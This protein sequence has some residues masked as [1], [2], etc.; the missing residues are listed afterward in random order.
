M[1]QHVEAVRYRPSEILGGEA[2]RADGTL[3]VPEQA[4]AVVIDASDP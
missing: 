1:M 4:V 3:S 2:M